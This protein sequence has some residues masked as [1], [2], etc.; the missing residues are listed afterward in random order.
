[1]AGA[2]KALRT[3]RRSQLKALAGRGRFAAAGDTVVWENKFVR[4]ASMF[5]GGSA[6]PPPPAATAAAPTASA[7]QPPPVADAA[8]RDWQAWQPRPA[9]AE[10]GREALAAA[11]QLLVE[12]GG[13]Q[14]EGDARGPMRLSRGTFRLQLPGRGSAP[15]ACEGRPAWVHPPAAGGQL[16]EAADALLRGAGLSDQQ[17]Q[18]GLYS[19]CDGLG[20][21]RAGRKRGAAAAAAVVAAD[22]SQA[23]RQR[24]MQVGWVRHLVARL[25][26]QVAGAPCMAAPTAPV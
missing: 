7:P 6:A 3:L 12:P 15:D 11:G 19:A 23:G 13:L 4:N 20:A 17:Q 18:P 10:A 1:V 22:E 24:G 14:D 21:P 16:D 5:E 2:E 25:G 9:E 26:C 8:V